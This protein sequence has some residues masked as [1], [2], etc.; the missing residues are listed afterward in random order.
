MKEVYDT[1]QSFYA[2]LKE[3]IVGRWRGWGTHNFPGGYECSYTVLDLE[4]LNKQRI[5]W[6]LG[7]KD[8]GELFRFEP[9]QEVIWV[10]EPYLNEKQEIMKGVILDVPGPDR[11][12]CVVYGPKPDSTAIET[13]PFISHEEAAKRIR[14]IKERMA[15]GG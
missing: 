10:R 8:G 5:V 3:F 6:R 2:D 15:S 4:I 1:W 11:K 7:K 14:E 13:F 9:T 12:F